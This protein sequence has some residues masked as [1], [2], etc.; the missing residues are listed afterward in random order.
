M[1]RMFTSLAIA[2]FASFYLD[3]K[4]YLFSYSLNNIYTTISLDRFRILKSFYNNNSSTEL[5]LTE[6]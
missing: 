1:S 5:T 2:R 3:L 6:K 4:I